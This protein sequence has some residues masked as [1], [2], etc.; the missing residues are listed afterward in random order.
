MILLDF[1]E[2][3][4]KEHKRIDGTQHDAWPRSTCWTRFLTRC[5]CGA[6]YPV[7]A[8]T[9]GEIRNDAHITYAVRF[10]REQYHLKHLVQE[11][12]EQKGDIEV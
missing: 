8:V 1:W 12:L 9:D 5:S 2:Q 10:H 7:Y 3:L 6:S 11:L 4:G